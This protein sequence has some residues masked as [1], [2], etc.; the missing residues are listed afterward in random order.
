MAEKDFGIFKTRTQQ[1]LKDLDKLKSNASNF[2]I[3]KSI[4]N[5]HENV[6]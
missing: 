4:F 2:I 3:R 6:T 1:Y 5:V